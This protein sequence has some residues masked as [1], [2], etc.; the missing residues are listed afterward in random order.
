MSRKP[1]KNI[2]TAEMRVTH[3]EIWTVEAETIEEARKMIEDL[4]HNV[5]VDETGGEVSD[6]EIASI[7]IT[8]N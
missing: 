6:W 3:R 7:K 8:K 1:K 4:D 2:Y 5:D